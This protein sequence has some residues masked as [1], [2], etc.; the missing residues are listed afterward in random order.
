[1]GQLVN[2][3]MIYFSFR[4]SSLQSCKYLHIVALSDYKD[5]FGGAFG[6][7]KDRVDK[8]AVGWE[9]HEKVDK[10]E[11]QKGRVT[12]IS[13]L[14]ISLLNVFIL[15]SCLDYKKG[16]GGSFGIQ[17]DRVDK[18]A[19]GWEHVENLDKHASQKGERLV[20]VQ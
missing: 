11:S 8:S 12:Y 10:H 3:N 17:A 18:S 15:S 2:P 6:V 14:T 16:F 20:K 19:H 4:Y 7:Q 1:M 5:G 9:H 13:F